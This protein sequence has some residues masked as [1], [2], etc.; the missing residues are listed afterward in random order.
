MIKARFSEQQSPVKVTGIGDKYYIFICLNE[1]KM[2]EDSSDGEN[3]ETYYEYDYNEIVEDK[4]VID[5]VDVKMNPEIYL[6]YSPAVE[7]NVV[8][9]DKINSS[10]QDLEEYLMDH[11]LFS[12]AKYSEGRYYNITEE[13]QRQLTSKIA[14]YNLYQQQGLPYDLLKWNDTG[15][16]CETWSIEELTQLAMEI[17]SYVTPLVEKQ[18]YY[19]K[20]VQKATSIEEINNILLSFEN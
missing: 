2:T 18:Q 1:E 13:K 4:D 12:K 19:E 9:V 5:V 6:S 16:V 15:D 8:K 14:M 20:Q 3:T 11:P 10:K 7:L 17:D